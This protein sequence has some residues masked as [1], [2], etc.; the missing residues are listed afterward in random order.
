MTSIPHRPRPLE[1]EEL[2]ADPEFS[3]PMISPD[4]ALLA[5][6]AP[7]T[8]GATSGCAGSTRAM[9]TPAA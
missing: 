6:L 4:G 1:A 2:F 5:Y 7:R 8:D 9:R 3:S